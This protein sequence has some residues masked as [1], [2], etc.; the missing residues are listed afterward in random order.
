MYAITGSPQV[1]ARSKMRCG[2][3]MKPTTP[4]ATIVRNV[5]GCG[6]AGLAPRSIDHAPADRSPL[7]EIKAVID[8]VRA[9]GV[10]DEI[11]E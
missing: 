2:R 4:C 6:A 7:S 9:Q 1:A 5:E 11:V 8:A 10:G 3:R